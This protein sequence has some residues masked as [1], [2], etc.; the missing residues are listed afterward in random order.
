M[1]EY[2][3]RDGR[4]GET[5]KSS[6]PGWLLAIIIIVALVIAAFAF[7]L[8]NIDQTK[9]A[10]LPD[11]KVET[12]GGQAPAFDVDT[13]DVNVGT[14]ETTIEVPTVSVDKAKDAK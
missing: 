4:V 11:V 14:K 13:A 7:G 9:N 2:E 12:T 1:A 10:A 3:N 8:I 5:R 6:A